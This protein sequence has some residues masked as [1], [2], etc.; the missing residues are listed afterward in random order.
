ME[1][2]GPM[3][4]SS[5]SRVRS[6]SPQFPTDKTWK[7]G[8]IAEKPDIEVWKGFPKKTNRIDSLV[9]SFFQK[10]QHRPGRCFLIAAHV[11]SQPDQFAGEP[12]K[13]VRVAMV[14]IGKPGVSK[15]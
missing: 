2:A 13:E 7:A 9:R 6:S 11:M 8:V 5:S 1:D 10:I 4:N 14:P 15:H 3:R 12:T